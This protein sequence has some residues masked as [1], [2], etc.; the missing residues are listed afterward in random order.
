MVTARRGSGILAGVTTVQR[1]NTHGGVVKGMC[2]KQ[3]RYYGV[4]YSADYILLR[5]GP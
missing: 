4:P 1:I 2:D 5:E 3:G